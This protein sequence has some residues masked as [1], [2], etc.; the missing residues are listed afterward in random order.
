MRILFL[1]T[2]YTLAQPLHAQR[3]YENGMLYSDETLGYLKEHADTIQHQWQ[4]SAAG[5][6]LEYFP[7]AIVQHF[8]LDTMAEKA[9]DDIRKG[10]NWHH[11]TK[12]YPAISVFNNDVTVLQK[13][14]TRE[15]EKLASP[16]VVSNLCRCPGIDSTTDLFS[17]EGRILVNSY[18]KDTSGNNGHLYGLLLKEVKASG[19]I[20]EPYAT[21]VRYA[22]FIIGP[23]PLFINKYESMYAMYRRDSV[24]RPAHDRFFEF[25]DIPYPPRPTEMAGINSKYIDFTKGYF[26]RATPYRIWQEKRDLHIQENL[27]NKEE[28]RQLL[29]AAVDETIRLGI[30]DELLEDWAF[31]YLDEEKGSTM[32]RLRPV[33]YSGCGN[34][35]APTQRIYEIAQHFSLFGANWHFFVQAHLGLVVDYSDWSIFSRTRFTRELETMGLDVPALLLGGVLKTTSPSKM[36]G[37]FWSNSTCRAGWALAQCKNADHIARQLLN[38]MGDSKLD[39]PNRLILYRVYREM[40]FRKYALQLGLR[41]YGLAKKHAEKDLKKARKKFPQSWRSSLKELTDW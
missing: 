16:L 38:A 31:Q 7:Y 32:M 26:R 22:N 35:P 6:S 14:S 33:Y 21:W 40:M 9:Y 39:M 13:R 3:F 19:E 4:E 37:L 30:P 24:P 12:K 36:K 5:D 28:F 2:F 29:E 11:F 23:E 20:P 34:N 27:E 18:E 8:S 25:I 41:E 15:K 1:L 10:I 17:L